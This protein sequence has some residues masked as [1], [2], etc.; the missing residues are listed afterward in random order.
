MSFVVCD[1][2]RICLFH[3]KCWIFGIKL[4]II[5]SY[6]PLLSMEVVTSPLLFLLLDTGDLPEFFWR[7][8]LDVYQHNDLPL[9][10]CIQQH[11]WILAEVHLLINFPATNFLS[12]IYEYC[13]P[14]ASRN[15]VFPVFSGSQWFL[16]GFL[17]NH[18]LLR[19]KKMGGIYGGVGDIVARR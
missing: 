15:T 18:S 12:C 5:F 9:D 1:F 14:F 17:V 6:Y 7:V 3:S 4:L 2:Q 19:Y 8:W 16:P 13:L 11:D 10:L